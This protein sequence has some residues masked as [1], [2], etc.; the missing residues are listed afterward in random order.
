MPNATRF[1]TISFD[2]GFRASSVRAAE[3]YERFGLRA[4]FNIVSTYGENNPVLYGDWALWNELAARG[5]SIQPHGYNH[6]NKAEVS[7][8]DA[9]DLILRC[10]D[11][12]T[13]N[14]IGFHS[15]NAVFAFP[16]NAFTPELEAWLPTV[17]RA[18]RGGAGPAI[19]PLPTPATVKLTTSGSDRAEAFLDECVADLL[20]RD[21]GWLVYCAHGLDGEGWGPLG[22]EYLERLLGRLTKVEN[23][24]VLPARDV[25]D[26]FGGSR[27]ISG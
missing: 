4:E 26:R 13:T 6:T 19:N 24:E 8:G 1:L 17:F 7:F 20:G 25:L 11:T 22:C 3:I 9:R 18:F 27:K 5:H 12:F 10:L 21:A 14:I 23:L 2:D 16:Y 15:A